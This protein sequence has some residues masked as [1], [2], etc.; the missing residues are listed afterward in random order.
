VLICFSLVWALPQFLSE[1]GALLD[2]IHRE[3]LTDPPP[4]LH[5]FISMWLATG[6]ALPEANYCVRANIIKSYFPNIHSSQ[7]FQIQC[8]LGFVYEFMVRGYAPY[9]LP[10][11]ANFTRIHENQRNKRLLSIE[12]PAARLYLASVSNYKNRVLTGLTT[13]YFL[14]GRSEIVGKIRTSELFVFRLKILRHTLL[15]SKLCR[16]DFYTLMIKALNIIS[17]SLSSLTAVLK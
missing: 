14:N 11:V 13:H 8:H 17:S 3:L 7:H 6:I 9:F 1:D 10:M 16:T 5:E 2:V 15:R 4:Q 12:K